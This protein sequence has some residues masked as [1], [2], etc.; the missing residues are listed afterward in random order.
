MTPKELA[1]RLREALEVVRSLVCEKCN[2]PSCEAA[3]AWLQEQD[4]AIDHLT[5]PPDGDEVERYAYL[6][7][8][9]QALGHD[10][11]N[12]DGWEDAASDCFEAAKALASL[13]PARNEGFAAGIEAAANEVE[14][15]GA[16][17]EW[18]EYHVRLIRALTPPAQET[19]DAE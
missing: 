16:P 15:S 19:G 7:R 13:S 6:S 5:A 1:E 11:E 18:I 9:L 3:R 12:T 10:C 17:R 4:T 2:A 8:V 14:G